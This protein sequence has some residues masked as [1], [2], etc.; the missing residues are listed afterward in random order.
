MVARDVHDEQRG[1]GKGGGR[2]GKRNG[3]GK[4]G[5]LTAVLLDAIG[6]ADVVFAD[7]GR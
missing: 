1:E 4:Q 7:T 2:K 3:E 5:Q 6:A